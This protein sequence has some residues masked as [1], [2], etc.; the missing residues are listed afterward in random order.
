VT[1]GFLPVFDVIPFSP[2]Y[3]LFFSLMFTFVFASVIFIYCY[4]SALIFYAYEIMIRVTVCSPVTSDVQFKSGRCQ[5]G[6]IYSHLV[7]S[8]LFYGC[9][10]GETC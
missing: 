2:L 3:L 8:G 10:S 4:K 9:P 5:S 7:G 1:V 6:L